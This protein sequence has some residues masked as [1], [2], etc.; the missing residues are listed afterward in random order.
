MTKV[1]RTTKVECHRN[2]SDDAN[3]QIDLCIEIHAGNLRPLAECKEETCLQAICICCSE[4]AIVV[5]LRSLRSNKMPNKQR[6][7]CNP[8]HLGQF[9][10]IC[11]LANTISLRRIYLLYSKH[12]LFVP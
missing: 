12:H 9:E 2:N 7:R 8:I 6:K 11:L 5:R 1:I 10:L 4:I 3:R